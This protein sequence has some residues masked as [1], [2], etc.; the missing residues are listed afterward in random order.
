MLEEERGVLVNLRVVHLVGDGGDGD[1]LGDAAP[2]ENSRDESGE[3][4]V[5][6]T[7][8]VPHQPRAADGRDEDDETGAP[9]ADG[10]VEREEILTREDAAAA[11][12]PTRENLHPR[13][14]RSRDTEHQ[15]RGPRDERERHVT[16]AL[17]EQNLGGTDRAPRLFPEHHTEGQRGSE[18]G[19]VEPYRRV[20]R[21]RERVPVPERVGPIADVVGQPVPRVP[22]DGC[23]RPFE[24]RPRR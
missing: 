24:R 21:L 9:K 13:H 19:E 6:E 3:D 2:D 20:D 18:G 11:V 4:F 10:G 5:R 23:E 15:Q 22:R 8:R 14:R 17:R 16:D 1:H 12:E 7:P